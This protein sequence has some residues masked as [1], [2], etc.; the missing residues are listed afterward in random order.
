MKS[1]PVIDATALPDQ[2]FRHHTPFWWGSTFAILLEGAGFVTLLVTYFYI[3][4][5]FDTWPPTGTMAPD[6]GVSTINVVMLIVSILPMWHAAH[7]ATRFERPRL[8]AFWL[9]LCVLFGITAA[10]LRLMEFAGLHTRWNSNAY[11]AILWTILLV[12]LAHI[13]AATLETLALGILM[14]SGPVEDKHFV[15]ILNNATYWY[16]V[17]LSWVVFY[18]IAILGPRLL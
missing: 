5:S 10:V 16:F 14:V 11:G 9:L 8:L 2:G 6:L 1:R 4:W 15:D 3:R 17:A 7:L 13:I 18:A 12:H